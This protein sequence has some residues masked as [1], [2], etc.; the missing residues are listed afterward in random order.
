VN[1]WTFLACKMST[2]GGKA[3][4]LDYL[5]N[6]STMGKHRVYTCGILES[7]VS[8]SVSVAGV[9]R[10]LGLRPSGALLAQL[11]TVRP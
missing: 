8:R 6:M 1:R 10:E 5:Y 2:S 3:D 4:A 11:A 7:A 9:L